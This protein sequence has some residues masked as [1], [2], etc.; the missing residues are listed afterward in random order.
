MEMMKIVCIESIGE[1]QILI[2]G[3]HFAWEAP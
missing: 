2:L 3:Q 1:F